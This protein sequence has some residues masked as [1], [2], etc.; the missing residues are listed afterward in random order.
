MPPERGPGVL[1]KSAFIVYQGL[2]FFI[3]P[4]VIGRFIYKNRVRSQD[5]RATLWQDLRQRLGWITP[6]KQDIGCVWIHA[7]S[8]GEVAAV[9]GFLSLWQAD[10]VHQ[11][12]VLTTT[13][14]TGKR[15]AQKLLG[16]WVQHY[17]FPID[18]FW[19]IN[20][21]LKRLAPKRVF[22]IEKE[23]WP[24]CLYLLNKKKIPVSLLNARMNRGSARFYCRLAFFYTPLFSM[25]HLIG[26]QSQQ[27]FEHWDT[28]I[29]ETQ[30]KQKRV[31]VLGN[32]KC[33]VPVPTIDL[34]RRQ[35]IRQLWGERPVVVFANTHVGEER[36]FL[37]I[38][39][40]LF[41]MMP[42][43]GVLMVPRHNERFKKVF[44][45]IKAHHF[46]VAYWDEAHSASIRASDQIIL[47]NTMGE[48]SLA[49]SL[50]DV[51]VIAGSFAPKIGG[52][53]PIEAVMQKTAIIT[54]PYTDNA[55]FIY[56]DLLDCGGCR[57]CIGGDQLVE[58]ILMLL[59]NQGQRTLMVRAASTYLTKQ[60]GAC[61][62]T[63]TALA[64]S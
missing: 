40:K 33:D 61:N 56:Q 29:S 54:G 47:A 20:L 55:D 12:I 14:L 48:L 49:Y 18:W 58:Q 62:R 44:S 34:Q 21:F 5:Y 36:L 63:M 9:Q 13:T 28:L 6:R 60:Q 11:K 57:R 17:Y 53:N 4:Y 39:P 41:A 19:S 24:S 31:R 26:V 35:T 43:L 8:V 64:E 22:L 59:Q 50:A 1:F 51:A 15:A 7:V 32:L 52:H 46:Q 2:W 10:N 27:D 37:E 16:H 45:L 42:N 25:F 3:L 38:L 30:K 23:L